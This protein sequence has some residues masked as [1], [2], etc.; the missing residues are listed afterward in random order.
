MLSF[1][2]VVSYVLV[3]FNSLT[4]YDLKKCP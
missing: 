3:T 2:F 4:C 1:I